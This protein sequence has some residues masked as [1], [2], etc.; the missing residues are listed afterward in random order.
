MVFAILT[1]PL[2]NISHCFF[3]L[4]DIFHGKYLQNLKDKRIV[5]AGKGK[6]WKTSYTEWYK[7]CE[8]VPHS[9]PLVAAGQGGKIS[10][11]VRLFYGWTPTSHSI[12]RGRE[13]QAKKVLQICAFIFEQ[14]INWVSSL[15]SA[16]PT[17][18][19]NTSI[20]DQVQSSASVL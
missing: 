9:P 15:V 18:T 20:S 6:N 14:N 11:L 4:W 16:W 12:S 7:N 3:R 5:A 1:R 8:V 19:Q 10:P 17:V 2:A 13:I